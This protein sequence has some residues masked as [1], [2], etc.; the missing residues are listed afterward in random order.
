MNGYFKKRNDIN[1]SFLD[2]GEQ[3]GVQTMWDYIQMSLRDPS[4]VGKDTFGPNRFKKLYENCKKLADRY[5]VC[6]TD[7][8]EADYYQEEMDGRL[9]EG[10]V[11]GEF[12]TFYERYPQLKKIKYDKAKK[13]WK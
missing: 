11:E 9:K 12:C 5:H 10:C 8:V 13:G 4:V 3:L 1:Q 6:F 2:A 7:D